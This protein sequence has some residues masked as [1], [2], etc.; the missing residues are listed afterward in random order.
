M[1]NATG[2]PNTSR[3]KKLTLRMVSAMRGSPLRR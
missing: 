3:P 1:A 2:T